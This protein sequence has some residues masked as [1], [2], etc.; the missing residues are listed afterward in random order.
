[1][2]G[3]E[4]EETGFD[5]RGRSICYIH[6]EDVSTPTDAQHSPDAGTYEGMLEG[7]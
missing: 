5:R 4:A 1:M 3:F 7:Q 2:Y 6:V